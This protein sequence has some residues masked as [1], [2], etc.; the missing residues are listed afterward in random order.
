MVKT[1][2]ASARDISDMS[3]VPGKIPWRRAQQPTPVFLAGKSR[4]QRSLAGYS[5]LD[6][7][8]SDTT[9]QLSTQYVLCASTRDTVVNKLYPCPQ[10]VS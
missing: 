10:G 4:G 9:E 7:K 8:E 5:P 1:P 3:L 6:H 2:P